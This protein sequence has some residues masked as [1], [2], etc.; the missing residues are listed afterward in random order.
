MSTTVMNPTRVRMSW[1][2]HH[3]AIC[4]AIVLL[5]ALIGPV[6]AA[7]LPVIFQYDAIH[8]GNYMP[9]AAADTSSLV[10]ATP[11]SGHFILPDFS[12]IGYSGKIIWSVYNDHQQSGIAAM[13][14]GE[15]IVASRNGSFSME[16]TGI[17][18]A[19]S[20]VPAGP[21]T[22]TKTAS[23]LDIV[24]PEGIEWYVSGTAGIEQGMTLPSRP[25]G[26]GPLAVSYAVSGTLKPYSA[27]QTVIFFDHTG[28]VMQ[29]GGLKA[30]DATGRVLPAT[31]AL[32]GTT[33]TWQIDDRNAIYPLTIDPYIVT[34]TAIL[35]ASDAAAGGQF[36]SSVAVYNDTAVIGAYGAIV[37]AN[38]YA[39][40]AYV[41][42]NNGGTW[43]Q[44]G[45]PLTASD[46]AAYDEFG[47]SVAVYN[48][49]AMIGAEGAYIGTNPNVGEAYVFKNNGGTW[50]QVGSPLTA[51]DA[52]A[53]NCFG[54]SVAVYNDTAV[55]GAV[56]APVPQ[57]A[58]NLAGEA[59]I[60]KNNGGTWSQVGSPLTASD[61]AYAGAFGSS[62]A[63][64]NDTAMISET[65][66]PVGAY[67]HA[68][69]TYVFENNGG[70][71]S[72]VGSPLTASDAA[73]DADFGS[74]VAVYND[75][76]VIGAENAEVGH[77][78]E[79]GEA[80][81]FKN[82]GGTWSQVGSP[83]TASDAA[84]D[85]FFGSSVAVYND[86]AVIGAVNANAESKPNAGEAYVF[87]VTPGIPPSV[88]GI[89]P[90]SGPTTGGTSVTI[91]GT[92]LSGATAVNF[93]NTPATSFIVNSDTSITAISPSGPPGTVAVTVT[94]PG[95]TNSV[96]GATEFTYTSPPSPTPQPTTELGTT[97][98][99]VPTTIPASTTV[100]VPASSTDTNVQASWSD[101]T[102][103]PESGTSSSSIT[104][105]TYQNLDPSTLTDY[106]SSFALEGLALNSVAYVMVV[107]KTNVTISPGPATI[108][109]SVP[110]SWYNAQGGADNIRVV[111]ISDSGIQD[112]L[113]VQSVAANTPTTGYTTLTFTSPNGLS[114]FTLISVQTVSS[115]GNTGGTA[116][117]QTVLAGGTVYIG[118]SGLNI[119]L[120]MGTN[121]TLAW[122][123][124]GAPRTSSVPNAT[125]D[126]VGQ[127]YPI[128]IT[129]TVFTGHTGIW[130]SWAPG[131]TLSNAVPAFNV[132]DPSI[133]V[134]IWDY[135]ENR[136]VTGST[137]PLGDQLGITIT[138]NLANVSQERGVA[139]IGNITGTGPYG[140][141]YQ[142]A[143]PLTSATTLSG[144]V[145]NT[146]NGTYPAGMYTL[147]ASCNLNNMLVNYPVIGK[148]ISLNET[149]TLSTTSGVATTL[150]VIAS[151][152]PT[153]GYLNTTTSF[154]ILGNNFEPGNTTV[155]FRNQSVGILN[156]T[157]TNV[158]T[159]QIAGTITIPANATTGLWNIQIVTV[160][161]GEN[162]SINAF[163]LATAA[164]P[165][166]TGVTPTTAWSWNATV[167][168]TITGTNFEP[169]LTT[170]AFVNQSSGLPFNATGTPLIT[171]VTPTTINGTAVVPFDAPK[172]VWN[173]SVTTANGGTAW[174][175]TAFTVSQFG[176]PTIT[177]I[178]PSSPWY[179]N[180]TISFTI[181]GTNFEPGLTTISIVNQSTMAAFNTTG[182]TV[183]T[184]TPTM[185]NGTVVV[186]F[187]TPAGTWNV[188]VTTFDGGTVWKSNAFTTS[189]IPAPTITAITP[190]SGNLNN[191]VAFTITGTNFQPSG[192]ATN[193]T[194]YEDITPT[195]LELPTNIISITPTSIVGT[196]NVTNNAIAGAYTLNVTTIDG[197][198]AST[199]GAFVVG[200]LA[201]PTI[202]SLTPVSG[203][204]NST[205]GF[206]IV[207]T[208]FEPGN[209]VVAFS[210][211]T[212]PGVV[213]NTP[214]LTNVTSTKIIGTITIPNNA[215]TGLYRLDITTTD[216][217][218]VN[219]VNAFTVN[220]YPAPTITSFTPVSGL[221]NSTVS[222]TITG[223]NFELNLT[224]VNFTYQTTGVLLNTTVLTNVTNTKISGTILIPWNAPTGLY[225]LAVNTTDGGG[226]TK[227]NAFTVNPVPAPTITAITPST[228]AK[229]STV[230][231]TL[232]GTNFEIA[233]TTVSISDVTSGTSLATNIFSVTPTN[234]ICNVTIP[235]TAPAGLY[236]L[237]V[238]TVDGGT[239][240]K[241]QTFTVNP[242][243]LPVLGTLSPASGY[244]NT[245]VPFTL[246]GNYFQPSGG[247]TMMLRA[248]GTTIPAALTSVN[249]TTIQGSFTISDT[250]GTGAYS[251]YVITT[252]GGFNSKP[253]AFTVTPFAKATISGIVPATGY[254][255]ATVSYTITGTNFEPGLTTVVLSNPTSGQLATNLYT[256]TATQI[257]GG[258]QIPDTAALGA[259]SLNVTT[260]DGGTTSKASAFTVSKLPVPTITT[261]TPSTAYVG[262]T[263]SF[264]ITG[265]NFEPGSLT[266]VNLTKA[267]QTP[268]QA[269]LTSV[270]STQ[271][272]GTVYIP[273]GTT[274]GSWNANVTTVDG[275]TGTKSNAI[276]IL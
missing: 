62:V 22:Y 225:Q 76:A 123:T 211:Q 67:S 78:T 36:G 19:G 249:S 182:L 47:S 199:P 238:T 273:I 21:G 82:N 89:S 58:A 59:Y 26:D 212:V 64:Y 218:V 250:A 61:A 189:K 133:D 143:L 271:I 15:M 20:L 228:G 154:T 200:N 28:P 1:L 155:A 201:I 256:A 37:G 272:T 99:S 86:T 247:T 248:V 147:T 90:A 56:Y 169:G 263:V 34:Q 130:Y 27:G 193:V 74:S 79:V 177:S 97:V 223:T 45:S 220:A 185:I 43:S 24:R 244:L 221:R 40:E 187:N 110:T 39:G 84:G 50:S 153:T 115:S 265:A 51:S 239:V 57:G 83:L 232:T 113:T 49:T 54:S 42:K 255:N 23:Q 188:S 80:Y 138:S 209:T 210:N 203:L 197:G 75:T 132:V 7:P 207:G 174:K 202:T 93:G 141:T 251:L 208:N 3:P 264:T 120:P 101:V 276:S 102:V 175:S 140:M 9:G 29:Y 245:T 148:T 274:I 118:E 131:N 167:P 108:T 68:G 259:W 135:T 105:T 134:S 32:S 204:T 168:F 25:G 85:A 275:G 121:T 231:F 165:T 92:G 205:V 46:A 41:F 5:L 87:T 71:W 240:N 253:N 270:Y 33:L 69:V 8:S 192:S 213:L 258:V 122:F 216:G 95:G 160:N 129:P 6:L 230:L 139:A 142:T 195:V 13:N 224:T 136:D 157:L 184:V 222:F 4:I 48:D 254:R 53:G 137:V 233:G 146:G 179:W 114:T 172:G 196:V 150:P 252:D 236:T 166:V 178:T 10:S 217:G 96:S 161:N 88:T 181:I 111:H 109:M 128:F 163:T 162:T 229:N 35:D 194:I 2:L 267:N 30:L 219:K 116:P 11:F 158:T 124:A 164:K 183:T 81:V 190:A 242:M 66:V 171:S 191:L 145:W 241:L 103:T 117:V 94:T 91:T 261:F 100:S 152:T 112:I 173:V 198:T 149:V 106:Q 234:I 246:T 262:D 268:I 14:S 180:A 65:N 31:L 227:V 144:P 260:V 12:G 119:T 243:P 60:F 44:V 186:P 159:T 176:K 125:I 269:T 18:H 126:I 55:I 63:V 215:P 104:T 257:I 156:A 206:T 77:A 73:P 266:I 16:I 38:K 170:I 235:A 214:V 98:T 70:T 52:A 237:A 151:V 17:G 226:V 107:T 127:D 72:Q